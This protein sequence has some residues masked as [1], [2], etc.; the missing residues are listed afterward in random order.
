MVLRE[1]GR[2][3]KD[4]SEDMAHPVDQFKLIRRFYHNW[5]KLADQ[6]EAIGLEKPE[7]DGKPTKEDLDGTID[8][9]LRLQVLII[10]PFNIIYF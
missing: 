9:I 8:G 4:K 6:I 3:R 5:P 7:L 1:I 10:V 2:I